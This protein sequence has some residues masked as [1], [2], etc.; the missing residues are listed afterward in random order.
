MSTFV[1]PVDLLQALLSPDGTIRSQAETAYQSLTVLDRI[2]GLMPH[3][4]S[5]TT[6]MTTSTSATT[7]LLATVLLRREIVKL[8]SVT[9]LQELFLPLFQA[10]ESLRSLQYGDGIN[11]TNNIS[12]KDLYNQTDKVGQCLAEVCSSMTLLGVSSD[13]LSTQYLSMILLSPSM[14]ESF[15][16]G[17]VPSLKLVSYLAEKVPSAFLQTL[18]SSHNTSN[19]SS[20][21]LLLSS[22]YRPGWSPM[23]MAAWTQVVIKTTMATAIVVAT[24]S[25]DGG[26]TTTTTTDD[27][28]LALKMKMMML[29]TDNGTHQTLD[30]LQVNVH[31]MEAT[32]SPCLQPIL[33]WLSHQATTTTGQDNNATKQEEIDDAIHSI[34]QDL[35]LASVTVPSFLAGHGPTFSALVQVCLQLATATT[36]RTM[37]E[38]DSIPLAA[39]QVLSSLLSVG[40]V[41]RL[42]MTSEMTQAMTSIVFPRCVQI[43]VAHA[44]NKNYQG[45]D[46]DQI[47]MEE[48]PTNLPFFRGSGIMGAMTNGDMMNEEDEDDEYLFALSLLESFMVHLDALGHVLPLAEQLLSTTTTTTPSSLSTS[49]NARVGLSLLT[50]AVSASPMAVTPHIPV[51]IQAVMTILMIV[52]TTTTPSHFR[53][54]YHALD[55]LKS[56]CETQADHILPPSI[57]LILEEFLKAVNSSCTKVSTK[58][59]MGIISFANQSSRIAASSEMASGGLDHYFPMYLPQLLQG[60]IQGPLSKTEM[61][62][63]SL[64]VR[65]Q[66]IGAIA[67]LA[68]ASM[69]Q[70]NNKNSDDDDQATF[71]PYFPHV[72]PGLL[73]MIVLVDSTGPMGTG[74][75]SETLSLA[76]LEATTIIGQAVKKEVFGH[77]AHQLVQWMMPRL[78]QPPTASNENSNLTETMLTACA[79]IASVLEDEFAPYVPVVI[80]MLLQRIQE[81]PDVSIVVRPSQEGV[82]DGFYS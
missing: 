78:Q 60:L 41:K 54:Q 48:P 44:K 67:A 70:D 30:D 19:G 13:I 77:D 15:S 22:W 8:H 76:S 43:M 47:W 6:T 4:L 53:I 20:F 14:Q 33:E 10:F 50:M 69:V 45:D 28:S 62:V 7:S 34:L 82:C 37:E 65:I 5:L 32:L 12:S 36:N 27:V 73:S 24:I 57:P 38:E 63:G 1:I 79:R 18:R 58:A 72:M 74:A 16:L 55:V 26:E 68:H 75:A 64:A 39:L 66:A 35:Q 11:K 23:A 31:S 46:D 3:L 59:S 80:P 51:I 61:D 29:M 25:T 49:A 52:T 71:V 40:D 9:H 17:H 81:A 21:L 56:L 42:Q 2:T